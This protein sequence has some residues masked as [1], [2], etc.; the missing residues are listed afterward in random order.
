MPTAPHTAITLHLT[1]P[2]F[3]FDDE[4]LE[5]LVLKPGEDVASKQTDNVFVGG[6]NRWTYDSFISEW[7]QG[8]G[9]VMHVFRASSSARL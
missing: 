3:V 6:R 7:Q 9:R 4:A 5:V 2:R 8:A 1:L